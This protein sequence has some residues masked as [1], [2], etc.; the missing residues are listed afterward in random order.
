MALKLQLRG[1]TYW[2]R[3]T[4]LTGEHVH[5]STGTK[6]ES[7]AEKIRIA[8]EG[9]AL[10]EVLNGKVKNCTFDEAAG[11]YMDQGGKEGERNYVAKLVDHFGDRIIRTITQT[12]LDNAGKK[13][14]PGCVPDTVNRQCHAVFI[15][16]YRQAH[17]DEFCEP[18]D[19]SRPKWS[20]GQF[21]G[22]I[23]RNVKRRVGSF[24]VE[25]D[26]AAPFVLAMSPAPAMV[27]TA[28]FYTGMRPSELFRLEAE[29]VNLKT[30]VITVDWNSKTGDPRLIPLHEILV[31][32]F[33]ALVERGGIL[34]RTPRGKPYP[35]FDAADEDGGKVSG[36][37]NTAIN[38][39][40]RRSEIKDITPYTARHSVS[41][42]LNNRGVTKITKDQIMGHYHDGD[43][44][45]DYTHVHMP[46]LREAINRLPV[47][48]AWA[49]A[50]WMK[51]PLAYASKLAEGTGKRNDL[52]HQKALKVRR[53]KRAKV[54]ARKKIAARVRKHRA[55]KKAA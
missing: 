7:E 19:W 30:R 43:P 33:T 17:R 16:I 25:Y 2:L 23:K 4:T 22:V 18:R 13:L 6:K 36:Q 27:M 54:N 44:S 50:P 15:A 28:L 47:I 38:G 46:T 35:V 1:T 53:E 55:E 8:K 34:F 24:A 37:M 39:A 29:H 12:E 11:V 51:D 41:T 42:E 48:E 49:N 40:R 32:M 5:E 52:A 10:N 31:P 21:N 20:G 26:H 9:R 14:Y 45:W 3:G